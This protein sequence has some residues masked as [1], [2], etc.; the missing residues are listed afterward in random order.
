MTAHRLEVSDLTVSYN[1]IPALHHISLQVT[2][3]NCV[4]L[5]C[6]GDP[7]FYG[8]FVGILMRLAGR[9]AIEIVPGV[10]SLMACPAWEK[11][12]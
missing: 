7:L 1:R 8:S 11:M 3:G 9:F 5:L 10:S 2:C 12:S 6:Q 4:A